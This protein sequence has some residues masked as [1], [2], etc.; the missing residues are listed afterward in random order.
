MKNTINKIILTG[1]LLSVFSVSA[2]MA[3]PTS[4]L[5][6]LND[7]FPNLNANQRRNVL[8]EGGMRNIFFA[9]E[10]PI[11]VPA[12]NSGINIM[13]DVMKRTP[14]QL[15]E[16]LLVVPYRT[17]TLTKLDAY[18]AISQV[19]KLSTHLVRQSRGVDIPLFAEAVRLEGTSRNSYVPDPPPATVLPSSETI[20]LRIRDYYFGNTYFRGEFK[21]NEHGVTLEL[22]NFLAVWYLV[23]PVMGAEKFAMVI[24]MEP[25]REGMLVYGLAGIDIPEFIAAKINLASNINRRVRIIINWISENLRGIR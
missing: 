1:V 8:S 21:E 14:V 3:N 22:T 9:R 16:T 17:R 7:L 15:I 6:T 20:H 18:N 19:E 25:I 12:S 2:L 24:Y 10:K 4:G 23:F 5:R 11:F 13:A